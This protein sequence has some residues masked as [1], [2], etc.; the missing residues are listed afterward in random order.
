MTLMM[1]TLMIMKVH[2][3]TPSLSPMMKVMLMKT[4][5]CRFGCCMQ[6]QKTSRSFSS[7]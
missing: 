1:K 7:K 2:D 6:E 5:T 4:S 3:L